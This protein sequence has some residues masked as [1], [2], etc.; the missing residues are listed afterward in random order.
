MLVNIE[1]SGN[2]MKVGG[3]DKELGERGPGRGQHLECK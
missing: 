1:I 2:E 3:W